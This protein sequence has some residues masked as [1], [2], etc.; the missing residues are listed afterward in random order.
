MCMKN[1]LLSISLFLLPGIAYKKNV[2]FRK[3]VF[4]FVKHLYTTT[5]MNWE[6]HKTYAYPF[7]ANRSINIM[8]LKN[9]SA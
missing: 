2:Y 7:S 1:V 6:L 3:K 9:V 8:V 5:V 4:F